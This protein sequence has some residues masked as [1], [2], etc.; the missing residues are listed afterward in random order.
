M[1]SISPRELAHFAIQLGAMQKA[2]EFEQLIAL[3]SDSLKEGRKASCAPPE[4]ADSYGTILE[5]GAG[6]GGTSWAWSKL[7]A[8]KLIVIDLPNGPWG[9]TDT[10]PMFKYIAENSSTNIDL[11]YGN[12][13]NSECLAA[14][15]E[16]LGDTKVDF[17]FIDGDHSYSGVKTDFITYSPFVRAGGIIAFHDALEHP[18][19][20]QCEVK[21][22]IDELKET[23]PKEKVSE[24]YSE[25]KNWGGIAVF[26]K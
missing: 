19:E 6:K 23:W 4:Y 10:Q 8:S 21:K 12:S 15:K 24:F 18:K 13:Q 17:L 26:R 25:P 14:L 2:E 20:T 9:G 22:F 1:I 11:I 3:V 5:I 16:R 7:G